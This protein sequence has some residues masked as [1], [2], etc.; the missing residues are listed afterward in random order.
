[1]KF[2]RTLAIIFGVLA[3]LLETVRRWHTWQENPPALFDDYIMGALLLSGAW[4]ASRSD[5]SGH[6]LLAAAWG[7]TC[8]LGYCSFFEQLRRYR[9][10]ESDPA[11]IPS[12]AILIV[13]GIGILLAIAALIATLRAKVPDGASDSLAN[14]QST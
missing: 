9:L 8:G 13:K 14:R 1:M 2:S 7:F 10:G 11:A 3:P 12:S 5:Y 4:L 6:K